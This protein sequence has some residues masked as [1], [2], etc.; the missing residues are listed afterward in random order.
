MLLLSG[1]TCEDLGSTVSG[2]VVQYSQPSQR[3]VYLEGTAATVTCSAGY[4]SEEKI[5]C[6]SGA[7]SGNLLPCQSESL[8]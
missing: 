2:G 7:W 5:T 4:F 3:G 1:L 8:K 6:T